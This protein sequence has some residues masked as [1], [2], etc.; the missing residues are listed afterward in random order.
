MQD[1]L[2]NAILITSVVIGAAAVIS[3]WGLAASR[4]Q[5]HRAQWH[6]VAD[7]FVELDSEL[8][9][10]WASEVRRRESGR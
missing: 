6:A 10:V 2:V 8:D 5:R 7:A 4:R 3:Y 1:I 9:R